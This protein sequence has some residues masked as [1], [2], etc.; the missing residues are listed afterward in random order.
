MCVKTGSRTQQTEQGSYGSERIHL[1]GISEVRSDV[2][3]QN[4]CMKTSFPAYG[5]FTWGEGS[6]FKSCIV[7]PQVCCTNIILIVI[8]CMYRF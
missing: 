8:A 6:S 2:I 5:E 3:V 1:A 4:F 7:N